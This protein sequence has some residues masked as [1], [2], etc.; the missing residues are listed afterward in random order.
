[1]EVKYIVNGQS[2]DDKEAAME[3]ECKLEEKRRQAEKLAEEK[4]ARRK[5][6]DE[7]YERYCELEKAYVKDYGRYHVTYGDKRLFDSLLEA[8]V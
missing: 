8:L 4:S 1:M 5:E 6:V 7:A 3:Y 2:F